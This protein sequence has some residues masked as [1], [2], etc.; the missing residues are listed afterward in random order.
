[1]VEEARA[2]IDAPGIAP[3]SLS[4]L[5]ERLGV[6]GGHLQRL[7]KRETGFSPAEY[8]EARRLDRNR[9]ALKA[10]NDVA[11]AAFAAGYGS[12]GRAY[13]GAERH[14]GM[15]PGR[16]R[17]GGT[18]IAIGFGISDSPLGKLLLAATERGLCFA[19]LDD[20]EDDLV[21][22][23][24]QEF[25]GATLERG[26]EALTEASTTVVEYLGG[27]RQQLDFALDAG[28]SAFQ[29][30][31][32]KA[33]QGIPFGETRTY[34]EIATAIGHAGAARAVGRACAS[35]PLPLFIPCHRV[36]GMSGDLTGYRYGK[37]RKRRLLELEA[38]HGGDGGLR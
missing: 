9:L 25:P 5:G 11:S 23:L 38:Q 22:A 12:L 3:L 28:G 31:V 21:E 1:M 37:E 18:G 20:S 17:K 30:L 36:L 2:L 35:N 16:L 29:L 4:E 15:P 27:R 8:A 33:L 32:W 14:L 6:S 19:A 24:R 26:D 34:S 13:A 10:G 7:F